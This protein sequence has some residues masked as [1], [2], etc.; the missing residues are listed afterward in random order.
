[1][2]LNVRFTGD[3]AELGIIRGGQFTKV[4]VTLHTRVHLV[5]KRLST[6][7]NFSLLRHM[8]CNAS[9]INSTCPFCYAYVKVPYHIEGDQPSYLIVAGLVFTPLSEPLIE[10][11]CCNYLID[12]LLGVLLL[13]S[14]IV[15]LI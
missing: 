6:V 15:F 11:V 8:A 10:Y 1:M 12:F 4:Q 9:N 13:I 14:F 7:F 5:L 2:I 3:V